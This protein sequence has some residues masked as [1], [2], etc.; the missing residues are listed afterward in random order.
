MNINPIIFKDYDIRGSYPEELNEET[1]GLIAEELVVTYKL[2]RVAIGRDVRLSSESL[3]KAMTKVLVDLGVNVTDLGLISTDM[4]FFAAGN[5]D[6]DLVIM[7]TG[8]HVKGKNGL[9]ISLKGGIALSGDSGLYAIRDK[10]VQRGDRYPVAEIKGTVN[11]KNIVNDWITACC[12]QIDVSLLK[13]LKIVVDTGNGVGG[14]ILEKVEK[15]LPGQFI[16]LYFEPDGNFPNHFPS[17][18]E[19]ENVAD[20][21]TKVVSEK[22][23]F[24]VAF[25]ADADRAFFVDHQGR[26]YSG[27]ILTAMLA[28]RMLEKYPGECVLYNAVC[29]RIVPETIRKYGGKPIRV[30]VGYSLIKQK[31]IG[32]QAIFAG[33][34]SGHFFYR[35]IFN[36]DSGL[37]TMLIIY[38]IM[39]KSG[40][41]FNQLASEFDVY[42]QSGEVNFIVDDKNAVIDSVESR[43][44][45]SAVSTDRLD[46]LS[47]WYSNGW[48]NLR[49]S[50]TE[51]LLRLNVEGDNEIVMQKQFSEVEQYLVGLGCTRKGV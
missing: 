10:I 4:H 12:K 31:M 20:L 18:I 34:H 45:S 48:F 14:L 35:D 16:N 47:V 2:H 42:T 38:E 7:V 13:P 49:P 41:S 17:P 32:Y 6:F 25:D 15:L 21:I 22:A 39:A 51:S 19:P 50:N 11:D 9:K 44:S 29:G 8:S 26:S 5:Y 46:G 37:I 3:Q 28:K 30:R 1:F 43:F 27:T 23:D 36:I 40:K 24:G 33:E